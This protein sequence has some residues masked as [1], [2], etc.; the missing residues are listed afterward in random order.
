MQAP[1]LLRFTAPVKP[2]IKG[3]SG[4]TQFLSDAYRFESF[5]SAEIVYGAFADAKYLCRFCNRITPFFR[6][7]FRDIVCMFSHSDLLSAW[8]ER[9]YGSLPIYLTKSR[10][11]TSTKK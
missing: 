1:F 8:L 2:L 4:D 10:P 9:A 7:G 5:R 11:A 6:I 3:S